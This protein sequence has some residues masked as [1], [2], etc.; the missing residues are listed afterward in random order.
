MNATLATGDHRQDVIVSIWS[1]GDLLLLNDLLHA[2]FVIVS[3]LFVCLSA[4][5][6]SVYF[7]K[8]VF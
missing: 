6:F 4:C 7:I 3:F 8:S 5:F 1:L 2:F